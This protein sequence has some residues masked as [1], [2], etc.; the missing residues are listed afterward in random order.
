MFAMLCVLCER[1]KTRNFTLCKDFFF[2]IWMTD[3]ASIAFIT[4]AVPRIIFDTFDGL[5]Q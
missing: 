2:T 4:P 3:V 1:W 5:T